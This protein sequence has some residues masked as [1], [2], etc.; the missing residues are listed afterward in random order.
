MENIFL[1]ETSPG[2]LKE[3]R[4]YLA[5]VGAPCQTFSSV[6]D[7]L[8]VKD[9]PAVVVLLA[10]KG[11]YRSDLVSLKISPALAKVPRLS[12]FPSG[13]ADVP[14]SGGID[15]ETVFQLPVDKGAF[16]DKVATMQKRSLRR[17]FEILVNLRP[18]GTNIKYS[19]KSLDF[20]KS[21]MAFECSADFS[22]GQRLTVSFVD[23]ACRKRLVLEAEVV[24]KQMKI[25]SGS[26]VYGIRFLNIGEPE[27]SDLMNFIAGKSAA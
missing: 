26:A 24:R 25:I 3:I 8:K 12:I 5:D 21:G 1:I 2:G 11:S 6:G 10:D 18:A 20:S 16:L 15:G 9:L 19:G 17:I 14:E 4:T 27:I 13:A 22:S 7:V 23:P